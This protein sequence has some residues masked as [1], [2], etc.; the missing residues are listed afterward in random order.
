MASLYHRNA[1]T[2]GRFSTARRSKPTIEA[3]LHI[4]PARVRGSQSSAGRL[5]TARRR[6]RT[7][8]FIRTAGG[9]GAT[10][11]R[12]ATRS[13]G[14]R[15]QNTSDPLLPS[16]MLFLRRRIGWGQ[17]DM[18]VV[19]TIVRMAG[20]PITVAVDGTVQLST[21]SAYALNTRHFSTIS[22]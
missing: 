8:M 10:G 16:C 6:T 12:A 9:P 7:F 11:P 20:H 3:C 15:F 22:C 21:K 1:L 14:A 2:L 19:T 4:P 13:I 5:P 18:G 17:F